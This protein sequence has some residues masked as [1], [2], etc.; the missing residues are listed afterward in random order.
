MCFLVLCLM[1]I[2]RIR[3]VLVLVS[4]DLMLVMKVGKNELFVMILGLWVSMI[5]IVFVC[6][7]VRVWVFWFG[8]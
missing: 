1:M 5:V 2:W 8:I 6:W 4:I 3:V 7:V